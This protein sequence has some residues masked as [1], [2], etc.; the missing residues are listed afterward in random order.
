MDLKV[1]RDVRKERGMTIK[2]LSKAVGCHR[3][4]ISGM[5]NGRIN[6]SLE[7]VNDVVRVLGY[8]LVLVRE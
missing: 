8:R 7:I 4:L 2:A 1:L 5:E 6:P 3:N